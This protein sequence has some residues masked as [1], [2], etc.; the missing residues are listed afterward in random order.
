MNKR[1]LIE[2][3]IRVMETHLPYTDY[4]LQYFLQAQQVHQMQSIGAYMISCHN[5][6]SQSP[7]TQ[8]AN[9]VFRHKLIPC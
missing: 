4:L 3:S 1:F 8:T 7:K 9:N 6:L 2:L 5:Y